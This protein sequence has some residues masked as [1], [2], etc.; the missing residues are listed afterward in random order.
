MAN[1]KRIRD[2]INLLTMEETET[3]FD[4][5][6]YIRPYD[7]E[8]ICKTAACIAGHTMILAYPNAMAFTSS[9][10]IVDD[11]IRS[12]YESAKD[13]LDLNHSQADWLFF[14]DFHDGTMSQ[15]K[16]KHAIKALEF[17]VE[18]P[19]LDPYDLV[20]FDLHGNERANAVKYWLRDIG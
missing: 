17:L 15:I 12:V 20:L 6:E 10:I 5:S 3:R 1:I 11:Q 2:L 19:D 18:Y 16:P 14:G 13:Y 7:N 4:M 9:D 8:P